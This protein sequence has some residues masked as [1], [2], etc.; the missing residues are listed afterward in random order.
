MQLIYL[1]PPRPWASR[2]GAALWPHQRDQH[3]DI[4][5]GRRPDD[6][7]SPLTHAPRIYRS[8]ALE[9]VERYIR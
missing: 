7:A 8:R 9:R 6:E 1:D 5:L 4:R 3:L 2:G